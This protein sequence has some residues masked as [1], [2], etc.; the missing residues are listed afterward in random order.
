MSYDVSYEVFFCAVSLSGTMRSAMS[1]LLEET[2][3]GGLARA[4]GKRTRPTRRRRGAAILE[5]LA[6]AC[7]RIVS[8]GDANLA[9]QTTP[10][11]Q[12]NEKNAARLTA[13]NHR[14]SIRK[15]RLKRGMEQAAP[16]STSTTPGGAACSAP[17]S[18]DSSPVVG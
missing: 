1:V 16:A 6:S 11:N 5:Q 10:N 2:A 15:D 7:Q 14:K 3:S 17:S 9:W 18:A 12:N 13:K 4:A 8:M